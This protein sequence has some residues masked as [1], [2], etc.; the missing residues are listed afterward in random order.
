MK[1][2]LW[3]LLLLYVLFFTLFDDLGAHFSAPSNQDTS[4]KISY[5]IDF[6]I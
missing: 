4:R 3:I 2:L 1:K 6:S 5:E